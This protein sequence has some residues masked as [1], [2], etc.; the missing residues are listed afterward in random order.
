MKFWVCLVL[1]LAIYGLLAFKEPFTTKSLVPNLEP[2][3]DVFYYSVPAWTLVNGHGFKMMA[4]GVEKESVVKPLYGWLLVPF[5]YVFHDFRSFY[6]LNISL[7]LASIILLKLIVDE[8][9]ADT[10]NK[11]WYGLVLSLFVVTN[12]YI[13]NLPGLLMSENLVIPLV[14]LTAWLMVRKSSWVNFGLI[15]LAMGL[16]W[17]AKSS[18]VP[19]IGVTGIFAAV[20]FGKF[21]GWT[22][23]QNKKTII[24][25]IFLFAILGLFLI[26]K[27]GK[28]WSIVSDE[29]WFS[30]KYFKE[31]FILFYNQFFGGEIRYLWYTNTLVEKWLG[32]LAG[33]GLALGL[34][35]K[36][37][38]F[39][40]GYILA[41][42]LAN[43]LFFSF[44]YSKEGRYMSTVVPLFLVGATFLLAKLKKYWLAVGIVLLV[45]VYFGQKVTINSF[46][47]RRATTLKRQ[48]M[49]NFR[50][51]E[52]PWNYLAVMSFNKYFEL[53]DGNCYFGSILNAYFF[54]M[55][56]NKNCHYLPITGATD[57]NLT[58]EQLLDLDMTNAVLRQHYVDLVNQGKKVYVSPFYGSASGQWVDH[59][60]Q[61]LKLF[62]IVEVNQGCLGSCNIYQLTK[63]KK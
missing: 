1:I 18:N 25:A 32:V 14:L 35:S 43:I 6:F 39:I 49:N 44:F 27:S 63:V 22:K 37:Y 47:E 56:S 52:T 51:N 34:F 29:T 48:V 23:L 42:V 9:F 61:L 12:F 17:L 5:F 21:D 7:G 59:Y 45:T 19:I 26:L 41:V 40:T 62:N 2:G 57:F 4:L 50:Q 58:R 53:P 3:P 54:E 28:I 13:Y 11:I 16:L 38:R 24:F 33:L 31:N 46:R 20:K 15:C 55:L 10:K 36:K 60:Q 8:I 30:T